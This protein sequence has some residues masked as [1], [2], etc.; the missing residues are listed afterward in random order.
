MRKYVF[1]FECTGCGHTE[2]VAN[3]LSVEMKCPNPGCRNGIMRANSV[4]VKVEDG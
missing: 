4:P 1:K 3:P 2:Y